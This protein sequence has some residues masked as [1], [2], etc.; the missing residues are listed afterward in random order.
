MAALMSKNQEFFDSHTK[1][2]LMSRLNTDCAAVQTTLVDFLGQRGLRSVIE[3]VFS[4]MV[5]TIKNPLSAFV[6][7]IVTPCITLAMRG[8]IKNQQH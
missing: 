3:I 2:E 1:G 4:L 7:I 5:I 6:S 8:I